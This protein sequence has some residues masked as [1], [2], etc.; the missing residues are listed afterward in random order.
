MPRLATTPLGF[1]I[2]LKRDV[3][4]LRR[5]MTTNPIKHSRDGKETYQYYWTTYFPAHDPISYPT[6]IPQDH[7]TAPLHNLMARWHCTKHDYVSKDWRPAV[8]RKTEPSVPPLPSD[9]ENQAVFDAIRKKRTAALKLYRKLERSEVEYYLR[10]LE[11]SPLRVLKRPGSPARPAVTDKLARLLEQPEYRH[12]WYL[13]E[14]QKNVTGSMIVHETSSAAE[15]AEERVLQ[16]VKDYRFDKLD[17]ASNF[18]RLACR[19]MK[20]HDVSEYVSESPSFS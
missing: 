11:H 2:S 15:E 1:C 5:T 17:I 16:L 7:P 12:R 20:L 18:I 9:E 8:K 19:V 14:P 13:R 3:A 10:G 6:L 4:S